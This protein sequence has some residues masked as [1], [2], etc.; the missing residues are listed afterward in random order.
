MRKRTRGPPGKALWVYT[1]DITL[2]IQMP[3]FGSVEELL[4]LEHHQAKASARTW[5]GRVVA[6]PPMTRI[7][8]VA[9]SPAQD[10]PVNRS[11]EAELTV[12]GATFTISTPVAMT[13]DTPPTRP[14]NGG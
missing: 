2:P 13:D 3:R 1:Y 12:L 10:R 8:I 4:E 6:E 9:D 7:L 5:S 11:L 14:M